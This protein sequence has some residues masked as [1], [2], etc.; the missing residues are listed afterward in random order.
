MKKRKQSKRKQQQVARADKDK[1]FTLADLKKMDAEGPPPRERPEGLLL[2]DIHVA[3]DV[4]QYR[5]P[6]LEDER[7]MMEDLIR[8]LKNNPQRPFEPIE[9]VAV[10]KRFF[11]MDGHHRLQAYHAAKWVG[12]IPVQY[13]RGTLKEAHADAAS[14]NVRN[15]LRMS[16]PEKSE[17]AWRMLVEG[18]RDP[19]WSRTWV[20]I[21]EKADIN[22]SSVAR[23]AKVLKTLG[24]RAFVMTWD[25]ARKAER[26]LEHDAMT[27]A[28]RDR[29]KDAQA[30]KIAEHLAGGPRLLQN[31]EITAR[32][33][34]MVSPQLPVA[35][36]G[37]WL[38]EAASQLVALA[39]VANPEKAGALQ[40]ALQDALGA[41]LRAQE[42]F[43]GAE[44]EDWDEAL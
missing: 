17:A 14:R 23:M 30:R 15:K 13:Y 10:G 37:E 31:M 34:A 28:A 5:R 36:I 8:A 24:P 20:E 9:V 4:F 16:K 42:D 26:A 39:E 6:P 1:R 32:A 41:Y 25:E 3:P 33:L 38:P 44:D 40:E 7:E 35:L 2:K 29:W 19:E 27:D 22:R 43:G 18:E 11:V 21:A 12:V